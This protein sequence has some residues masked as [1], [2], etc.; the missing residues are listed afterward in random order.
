MVIPKPTGGGDTKHITLIGF[1][2]KE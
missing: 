1:V 2:E